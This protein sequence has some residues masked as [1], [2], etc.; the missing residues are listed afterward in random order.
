MPKPEWL[1][2][3]QHQVHRIKRDPDCCDECIYFG[4]FVKYSRHHGS[5]VVEVREC[6]IHPGC[7]NTKYSICCDDFT[8][9]ELV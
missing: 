6:D 9:E 2:D 7:F 4:S 3:I 1:Q 8:R 5:E